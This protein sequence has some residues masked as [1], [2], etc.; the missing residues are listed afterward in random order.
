MSSAPLE[1]TGTRLIDFAQPTALPAPG[2]PK[3]LVFIA[4]QVE[5]RVVRVRK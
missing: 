2:S 4:P 1:S 5:G 3:P